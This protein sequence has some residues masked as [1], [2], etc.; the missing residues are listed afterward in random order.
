MGLLSSRV[1]KVNEA[2]GTNPQAAFNFEDIRQAAGRELAAARE[3]SAQLRSAAE[4]AAQSLREEARKQGYDDG[5]RAGMAEAERQIAERIQTQA[6]AIAE[7]ELRT[8]LPAVNATVVQLQLERD[9][10]LS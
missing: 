10:S 9:L 2:R 5:Y 3:E 8:A 1:L 4:T 6:R 7:A